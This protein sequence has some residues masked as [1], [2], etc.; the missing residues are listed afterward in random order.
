MDD[1]GF[2]RVA[3]NSKGSDELLFEHFLR[4]FCREGRNSRQGT[5]N[6]QRCISGFI[7]LVLDDP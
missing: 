7:T 4:N 5:V 2:P 6:D 1:P 3:P